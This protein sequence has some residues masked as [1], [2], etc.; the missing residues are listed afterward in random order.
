M[1]RYTFFIRLQDYKKYQ[2]IYLYAINEEKQAQGITS[3]AFNKKYRLR[4]PSSTQS[5]ALKLLEY[6]LITR[7]DKTYSIS[8][9]LMKLW[10][11]RKNVQNT[12]LFHKKSVEF[13]KL[14]HK[15]V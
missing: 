10:L 11:D 1:Q 6:N 4:S 8:D 13:F 5:A 12:Q 7:N 15:T 14:F 2:S 9:P 3:I